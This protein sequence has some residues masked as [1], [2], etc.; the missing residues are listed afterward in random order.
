VVYETDLST[1]SRKGE[2][3][4][5]WTRGTW[6]R[7]ERDPVTGHKFQ[8]QIDQRFDDC[9]TRRYA[10]HEYYRRDQS[11]LLVGSGTSNGAWQNIIPGSVAEGIWRATCAATGTF[12][13]E[14]LVANIGSGSWDRVGPSADNKYVLSIRTDEL[15]K[16]DNGFVLAISRSDY[17]RPTWIHGF[18]IR[19]AVVAAVVDCANQRSANFGADG[20]ISPTVRVESNRVPAG[21]LKFEAIAP[22][23]FLFA[24]LRQI[25]SNAKPI[26]TSDPQQSQEGGSVGTAWATAKGYLVT[27]S[28][29]VHEGKAID[30]YSSGQRVGTA[31]IVADDPANDLAL[32]KF[33]PIHPGKISILPLATKGAGLGKSVFTLGYPEPGVLGQHV[34]MT[35]GEVSST[36][37]AGDDARFLQISVPVQPGNSGGPLL[38]WDGSVFGVVDSKLMKFAEDGRSPAPENVNYAVKASYLRP[39]LEDLPDLG[40]YVPMKP[41]ANGDELVEAAR[42]AVYMVVVRR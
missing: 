12:A 14:P 21:S 36:S 30:V 42:Q 7:P 18:A 22:G 27:A 25:C 8:V 41:G 39:M 20:Y 6:N 1:L 11:G 2:V 26:P 13:D 29:V 40:N 32:L 37:G 9:A 35:A 31:S 38:G 5:S 4:Q 3:V 33:A 10:F 19:Y 24:R 16:L 23:S 15:I 34:K 28:H 17:A